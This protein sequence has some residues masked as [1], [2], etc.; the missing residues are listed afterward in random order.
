MIGTG[1]N[2]CF[3]DGIRRLL[4]N[5]WVVLGMLFA[6]AAAVRWL[7]VLYNPR[8]DGFLIYQG[9]PVS[10][11]WAYTLKAKS[12][13][14]GHGIPF[15]QPG[16]RPL[17]PITLACFYTWFGFSLRAVTVLNMVIAGFT[18]ALIY[19]CGA[20]AFNRFCG[21][22][23]A[24]FFCIDPSQLVQ[25][26]QAGTEPL[27]LLFFVASVY[28]MLRASESALPVGFFLSGIFIGLS[29]LARTLTIFTL[30]FYTGVIL[31]YLGL[32]QRALT[33]AFTYAG[34]MLLGCTAVV[35]PWFIRQQV[36]YGI[37]SIS[38]NIGEALY[39]ASSP[40]YGQ[41]TPK[42]HQEAAADGIPNTVGD[43][44]RYFMHRA[45]EN[46][47]RQPGFYLRAVATSLWEYANT[48][49]PSS[50]LS[51]K[52]AEHFSKA[53]KSQRVLLV[54]LVLYILCVS[55][56]RTQV[57]L[58]RP[59]LLFLV[60]SLGLLLLYRSLP[61]WLAFLPVV[62][63]FFCGWLARRRPSDTILFGSMAMA[64]LG[65]A[66]FA[67]ATLF[68]SILMTDWLFLLY[69]LAALFVPAEALSRRVAH[70]ADNLWATR[71][72]DI[73][74]DTSF[75]QA[76]SRFARR[77]VFF[78]LILVVGWFTVSAVRIIALTISNPPQLPQRQL[79]R[80]EQEAILRR[81]QE[82][83][84]EVVHKRRDFS[85]LERGK[86]APGPTSGD[87]VVTVQQFDYAYYIPARKPGPT[88]SDERPYARTLIVLSP[89]DFTMAGEVPSHLAGQPVVFVGAVS[90]TPVIGQES[91]RLQVDGLAI[92]P[93][94]GEKRPDFAHAICAPDC[95]EPK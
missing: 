27:G 9:S 77:A 25:T 5:D 95:P 72:W 82:P 84:F 78:V 83:P 75:Q 32:R 76:L 34:V 38:D 52:Y 79:T 69:F 86:R 21:L 91:P 80:P 19:L 67:N 28:A 23:A 68:R 61:V 22:G 54:C 71:A 24:L 43:R 65:S 57:P 88:Y 51:A 13:A 93:L 62:I 20:R 85:F 44:Y 40:K 89:F 29:N 92:I 6:T 35:L 1:S 56:M 48:F 81:L 47:T 36:K 42:V 12:I 26:S 41:W 66:M 59:N 64:V 3:R 94:N 74:E 39:A 18:A 60:A 58:A 17:Y 73:I 7:F 63:G 46:I 37:N 30:P 10:D 31:L 70:F 16:V 45:A 14:Q 90:A 2:R 87:F 53:N 49:N 50:R 33:R 4:A 15:A 55:L 11:G 8:A